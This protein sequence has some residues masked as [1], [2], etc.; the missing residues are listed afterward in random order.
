MTEIILWIVYIVIL[1]AIEIHLIC[2]LV[3][4]RPENCEKCTG[5]LKESELKIVYPKEYDFRKPVYCFF[6]KY[7]Y[8]VDGVE[9]ELS[10][11]RE[12]LKPEDKD[13]KDDD[14]TVAL[15]RKKED[16]NPFKVPET[17]EVFYNEKCPSRAYSPETGAGSKPGTYKFFAVIA[18]IGIV[19]CF[20]LMALSICDII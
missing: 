17:V 8:K 10:G 2:I 9:Y 4:L 19:A 20:I 18:A 12:K 1:V 15:N 3:S 5:F 13:F 7:T 14:Y 16:E 6:Y 11:R